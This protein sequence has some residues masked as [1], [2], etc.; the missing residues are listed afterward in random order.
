MPIS[1]IYA[2]YNI[3]PI[4]YRYLE[5]LI[6]KNCCIFANAKSYAGDREVYLAKP[7]KVGIKR[8]SLYRKG[9]YN[10]AVLTGI[11]K[12]VWEGDGFVEYTWNAFTD[13]EFKFKDRLYKEEDDIMLTTLY[14]TDD[15]KENKEAK[16]YVE[17]IKSCRERTTKIILQFLKD[18]KTY[19][20]E[21]C[22]KM[23]RKNKNFR[24]F[25]DYFY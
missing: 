11:K 19:D 20:C 23:A 8:S 21:V 22:S 10:P 25:P 6:I 14:A 12:K 17:D 18:Y 2:Q 24:E 16:A 9:F 3:V 1:I 7:K 15:L 5:C 13:D 4:V